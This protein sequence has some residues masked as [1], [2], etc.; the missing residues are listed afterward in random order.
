MVEI[1]RWWKLD[2]CHPGFIDWLD[3]LGGVS[4]TWHLSGSPFD[5]FASKTPGASHTILEGLWTYSYTMATCLGQGLV[6]ALLLSAHYH[7]QLFEEQICSMCIHVLHQDSSTAF[8]II[9]RTPTAWIG[10][11]LLNPPVLFEMAPLSVQLSV[12]RWVRGSL[13]K[14][15]NW[16]WNSLFLQVFVICSNCLFVVRPCKLFWISAHAPVAG[17]T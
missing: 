14:G 5:N 16:I 3:T 13:S 2:T 15:K 10:R 1:I 6:I 7:L 12:S 4:S 9:S 17:C 8:L 11:A